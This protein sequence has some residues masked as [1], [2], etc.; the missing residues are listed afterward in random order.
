METRFAKEPYVVRMRTNED[1]HLIAYISDGSTIDVG[2]M[3]KFL[4]V[5]VIRAEDKKE[6]SIPEGLM[7]INELVDTLGLGCA[8]TGLTNAIYE[9]YCYCAMQSA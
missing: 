8:S 4:A 1:D 2:Y 5:D 7:T 9:L 6:K 3:G